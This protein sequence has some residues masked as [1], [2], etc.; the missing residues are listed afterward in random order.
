[1]R[2]KAGRQVVCAAPRT[3]VAAM[4]PKLAKGRQLRLDVVSF[5]DLAT[6]TALAL[7]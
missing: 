1:M 3:G 7:Q 6:D 4:G 5:R 2:A